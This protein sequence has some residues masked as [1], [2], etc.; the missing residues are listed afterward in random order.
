MTKPTAAHLIADARA[1]VAHVSAEAV[2]VEMQRGDVLLV[3]VREANE[4]VEHGVIRG[5]IHAP[6]GMLEFC[7]DPTS[8]YFCTEFD[9]DR[10]T[11]LYCAS[12]GRAAL[13]AETLTRLGYTA[14]TYLHGGLKAW[15]DAGFPVEPGT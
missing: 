15:I 12:G 9:P 13:G 4:R 14:V 8:A 3:D 1:Q 2:A 5:S 7:A 11:I 10:R 6:R